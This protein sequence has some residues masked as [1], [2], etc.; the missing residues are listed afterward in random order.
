MSNKC[1]YVTLKGHKCKFSAKTED[2][3]CLKHSKE[4]CPICFE[5]VSNADKKRLTCKHTF[6]LGCISTWYV[7]ADSC[8]VCRTEQPDDEYIKFKTQ[9]ED[10][11]RDKYKD[12]LDS[13]DDEVRRL[14]RAIRY[15]PAF[16]EN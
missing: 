13:M 6:H 2:G 1:L 9:V 7:Q 4:Q 14:R 11:M 16:L 3:Y 12:A 8:P 15:R 5:I 10:N